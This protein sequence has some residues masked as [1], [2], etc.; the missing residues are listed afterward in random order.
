MN[1]E[2]FKKAIFAHFACDSQMRCNELEDSVDAARAFY[3]FLCGESHPVF[4]TLIQK[5]RYKT[6]LNLINRYLN[7]NEK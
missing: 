5:K 6:K 4:D 7:Q 1:T 2:L 3:L